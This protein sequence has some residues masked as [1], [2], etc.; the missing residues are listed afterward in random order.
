MMLMDFETIAAADTN[1]NQILIIYCQIFISPY[2]LALG[3]VLLD[4]NILDISLIQTEFFA[5]QLIGNMPW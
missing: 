1:S 3:N 5:K 4:K 2:L